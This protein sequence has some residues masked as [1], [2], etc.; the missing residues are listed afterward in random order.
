[1]ETRPAEMRRHRRTEFQRRSKKRFL[2]R[3]AVG[4]II[5]WPACGIVK[6][7]RLILFPGIFVFRRQD[8]SVSRGLPVGVF[9]LFQHDSKRIA[10]ARIGV[11]IQVVAEDLRHAHCQFRGF[12]RVFHGVE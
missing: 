11:E 2:Q 12:A 8:F 1:M 7:Q 3:L 4:R 5:S 6:E 9:F 10:F